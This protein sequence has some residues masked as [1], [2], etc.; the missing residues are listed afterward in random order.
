MTVPEK[1]S[2][3]SGQQ[4]FLKEQNLTKIY[5]SALS[6]Q[7]SVLLSPLILVNPAKVGDDRK[8][9]GEKTLCIKMIV[10]SQRGR[11]PIR[12]ADGILRVIGL[13]DRSSKN[14]VAFHSA[15]VASQ[16]GRESFFCGGG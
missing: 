15:V 5:I 9:I 6:D 4:F 1:M 2:D 13:E 3:F 7:I 12:V 16:K 14:G 11:K 8:E 10:E